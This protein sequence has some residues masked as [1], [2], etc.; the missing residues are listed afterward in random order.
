MGKSKE[1]ATGAAYVD[2][3]GDTMTGDLVLDKQTATSQDAILNSVKFVNSYASPT[4]IASID[5]Y[6]GYYDNNIGFKFN[7]QVGGGGGSAVSLNAMTIDA[8]GRVTMPYQP[9]FDG[10]FSNSGPMAADSLNI[11]SQTSNSGITL[12]N[13]NT[14]LTVPVEGYYFVHAAQLAYPQNADYGY[15]SIMVNGQLKYHSHN[16]FYTENNKDFTATKVLHL[17]AYD[18]IEFKWSYKAMAS[19]WSG[20]HSTV[21]V[22]KLG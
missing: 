18:Y 2:A 21:S 9:F 15:F 7:T 22:Y 14:R 10:Q 4:Y 6:K 1:L 12:G 3:S 17:G 16:N 13:S 5:A 19:T 11:I 8:S 20:T